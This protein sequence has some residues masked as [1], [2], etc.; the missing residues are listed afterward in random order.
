MFKTLWEAAQMERL[1]RIKLT[2]QKTDTLL[3]ETDTLLKAMAGHSS[4]AAHV[5]AVSSRSSA[6]NAVPWTYT[7]P[8]VA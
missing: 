3:Q 7:F 2:L 5:A 8:E 4:V 6:P 1:A